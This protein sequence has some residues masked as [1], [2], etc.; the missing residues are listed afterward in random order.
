MEKLR[1]WQQKQRRINRDKKKKTK[2]VITLGGIALFLVNHVKKFFKLLPAVGVQP[3][4]GRYKSMFKAVI[5]AKL[6]IR[7]QV[8]NL[9]ILRLLYK[10]IA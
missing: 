5:T 8:G 7:E 10:H 4:K 6:N 9:F 3:G 2:G 1:T